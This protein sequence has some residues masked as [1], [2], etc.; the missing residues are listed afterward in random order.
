MICDAFVYPNNPTSPEGFGNQSFFLD[1]DPA[2]VNTLTVHMKMYALR[3][4]VKVENV[5]GKYQVWGAW[6]GT[7]GTS[8]SGS[9][10]GTGTG[11]VREA[12]RWDQV[13]PVGSL[14]PRLKAMGIRVVLPTEKLRKAPRSFSLFFLFSSSLAESLCLFPI[15]LRSQP[16][17]RIF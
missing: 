11:D 10:S 6:Q 17:C 2:L 1:C 5:T 15:E 7:S 4:K 14:D 12:P 13:A 9:G 8:G 3:S 16:A